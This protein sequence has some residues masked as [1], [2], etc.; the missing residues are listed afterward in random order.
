M[1]P[2]IKIIKCRN[3]IP[4]I[5][6]NL[7]SILFMDGELIWPKKYHRLELNEQEFILSFRLLAL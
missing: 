7:I 5:H 1:V 4:L 3:L 6:I 2:L